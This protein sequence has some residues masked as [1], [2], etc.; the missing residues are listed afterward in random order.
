M[1]KILKFLMLE[2]IDVFSGS[3]IWSYFIKKVTGYQYD[4][5]AT[6]ILDAGPD[7]ICN[8]SFLTES[9]SEYLDNDK[10]QWA[11]QTIII[12]LNKRFEDIHAVRYK[13][14]EIFWN[15]SRKRL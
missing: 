1:V 8:V 12:T 13:K 14:V 4:L 10:S 2:D 5:D 3:L 15:V 6:G 11:L 9:W 7:I